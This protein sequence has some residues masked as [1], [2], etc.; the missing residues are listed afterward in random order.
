MSLN[1]Y[2]NIQTDVHVPSITSSKSFR[3]SIRILNGTPWWIISFSNWGSS[4]SIFFFFFFSGL[5]VTMTILD[6]R[7]MGLPL[8][9][10]PSYSIPDMCLYNPMPWNWSPANSPW[11]MVQIN[12]L[13]PIPW[14][15]CKQQ[16]LERFLKELVAGPMYISL[17]HIIILILII[18]ISSE[19]LISI[20]T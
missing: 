3:H 13:R 10:K 7:W 19:V 15:L 4:V 9:H 14:N 18:H 16:M 6:D 1:F 11:K 17:Y 8:L 20:V 12:I 2:D 5:S